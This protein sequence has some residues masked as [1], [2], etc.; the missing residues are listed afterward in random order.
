MKSIVVPD[1]AL[2][3]TNYGMWGGYYCDPFGGCN[4]L[5]TISA[6]LN[7]TVKEFLLH[8]NQ[9][10]RRII[11]RA[12]VLFCLKTIDAEKMLAREEGRTFSWC[13]NITLEN[14]EL[15][16]VLAEK[17]IKAFELWREI[18]MFL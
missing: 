8:Q 13:E 17:K 15:K 5:I 9:V 6:A 12:A 1:A 3:N 16:G 2:N 11:Q 4:E 7:I 14:G 10:K 18:V